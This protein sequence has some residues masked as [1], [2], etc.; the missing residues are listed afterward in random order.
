ML[1]CQT[2]LI[3]CRIEEPAGASGVASDEALKRTSQIFINLD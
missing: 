1:T 3:D 2:F